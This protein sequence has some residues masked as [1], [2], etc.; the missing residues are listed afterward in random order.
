MNDKVACEGILEELQKEI[1]IKELVDPKITFYTLTGWAAPRTMRFTVKVGPYEIMVLT[2]SS[3][4]HNF[5]SS[6]MA[7][8]LRLLIIP[9]SG[10]SVRVAN[11]ETLSCTGKFQ[12]V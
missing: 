10:F 9:I 3:S 8:M 6:R 1:N 12:Q 7:N 5:I 4:T 11:G 2:D